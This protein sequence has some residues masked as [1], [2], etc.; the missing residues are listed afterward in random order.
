M[1]REL[2]MSVARLRQEMSN[3]ELTDWATFFGL[4]AQWRELADQ[5]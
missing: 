2:S 5:R 3:A 1:A 4:E